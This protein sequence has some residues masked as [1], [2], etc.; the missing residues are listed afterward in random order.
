MRL[1]DD[2]CEEALYCVAEVIDLRRRAGV[3]VPSW[4]RNLEQLL[5]LAS[6][7]SGVSGRGHENVGGSERLVTDSLIGSREAAN[8]LGLSTRQVRRLAADLDGQK[9]SGRNLFRRSTVIEYAQER[10]SERYQRGIR[11]APT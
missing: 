11:A 6:L 2:E 4:M 3:P 1:S 9:C 8:I 10:N 7:T 5:N